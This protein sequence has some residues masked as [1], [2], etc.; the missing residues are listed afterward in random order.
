M[1]R[2]AQQRAR[3]RAEEHEVV[4]DEQ[5]SL[6]NSESLRACSRGSLGV[7]QVACR[8]AHLLEPEWNTDMASTECESEGRPAIDQANPEAQQRCVRVHYGHDP[9]GTTKGEETEQRPIFS[10]S[11]LQQWRLSL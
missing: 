8:L 3:R 1:T 2:K 6:W 11:Q 9:E 7:K 5:T 4:R 10:Q